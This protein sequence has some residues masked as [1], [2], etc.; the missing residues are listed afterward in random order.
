MGKTCSIGAVRYCWHDTAVVSVIHPKS[1]GDSLFEI[2]LR[3]DLWD[4]IHQ[5]FRVVSG[6][7]GDGAN[8]GFNACRLPGFEGLYVVGRQRVSDLIVSY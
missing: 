8:D 3:R 4:E 2:C 7:S 6:A 5:G 1:E